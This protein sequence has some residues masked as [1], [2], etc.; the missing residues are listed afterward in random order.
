MIIAMA[1]G[2]GVAAP[3]G[4][5]QK[6]SLESLAAGR[7]LDR[8]AKEAAA[9]NPTSSLG[10]SAVSGAPVDGTDAVAAAQ[11]GDPVAIELIVRLGRVLGIGIA[12]VINIFDPEVVAIGGGVSTAGELLLEP[13]RES[14]RGYVLPGVGTQTQIRIARSGVTAGVR[15]AA[16]L[17]G[18]E[19]EYEAQLAQ[20]GSR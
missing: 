8:L 17:A 9:A 16:L 1:L 10:R 15:G 5:P 18:Q 12:N 11:A 4:F 2:D 20:T 14:A 3:N 7:A 13:A 19:L 6:G